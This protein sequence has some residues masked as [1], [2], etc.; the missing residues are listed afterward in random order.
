MAGGREGRAK[1]VILR[2]TDTTAVVAPN[3]PQVA[4]DPALPKSFPSLPR[5]AAEEAQAK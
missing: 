4:R 2:S 5:P 3:A 1:L